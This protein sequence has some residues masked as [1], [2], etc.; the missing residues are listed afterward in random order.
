M[1]TKNFCLPVR[2]AF[3]A[4][5]MLVAIIAAVAV[6]FS[7]ALAQEGDAAGASARLYLPV[8]ANGAGSAAQ[9]L[10]DTPAI[11]VAAS[12][13]I[14]GEWSNPRSDLDVTPVT[15]QDIANSPEDDTNENIVR[16]GRPISSADCGNVVF[17]SGFGFDGS[18]MATFAPNQPFILGQFTHY[19]ANIDTPPIP[20]QFVDL[21]IR[22]Q[23]AEPDG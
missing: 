17:R 8:L 12:G 9:V 1:H 2:S 7:T 16:Y 23:I 13:N 19:N 14:D 18:N 22:V 6:T 11:G 21:A 4:I 3:F 5:L 15:C 20:M 10:V